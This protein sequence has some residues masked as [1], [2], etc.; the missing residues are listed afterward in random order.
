MMP[1]TL[2]HATCV[3]RESRAVLLCGASGSGKSDLALRLV[4]SGWQLVADDQTALRC[5]GKALLASAPPAISGLIEV[6]GL[7]L[8][9]L[10]ALV[11]ARV[12]L[13]VDL[14]APDSIER[15]PETRHRN[16]L[17]VRLPV[18]A[19]APFESSAV[20]KLRWALAAAIRS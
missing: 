5:D 12:A 7:G 3:A 10:P 8:V 19:L 2:R 4:E 17:G 13:V 16:L 20:A 1:E 9:K 18:L 6:R 11:E 14:V 15:L